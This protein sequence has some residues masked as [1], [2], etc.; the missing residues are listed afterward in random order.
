MLDLWASQQLTVKAPKSLWR[1]FWIILSHSGDGLA[2]IGVMGVVFAFGDA[3]WRWRMFMLL[4]ADIGTALVVRVVKIIFRRRR[5]DGDWGKFYR[6]T[7]PHSFPSG[8]AGRGG[9]LGTMSIILGPWWFGV[10]VFLWGILVALSRTTMN[11]H[12][13]SDI[14]A[15]FILG[16]LTSVAIAIFV[17]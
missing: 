2:T 15:G 6:K 7:D 12:H 9:A 16:L 5:P 17:L 14:V 13:A 8:H 4:V 3:S 1:T 10:A 11:V